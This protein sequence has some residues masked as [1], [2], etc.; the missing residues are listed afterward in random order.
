MPRVRWWRIWWL[1]LP[2]GGSVETPPLPEH[3]NLT[4]W[5]EVVW[6]ASFCWDQ[7]WT[8][9]QCCRNGRDLDVLPGI[10]QGLAKVRGHPDC[11]QPPE[12]G[13]VYHDNCCVLNANLDKVP[14]AG[15]SSPRRWCR[16]WA[17]RATVKVASSVGAPSLVALAKGFHVW[18]SD[19]RDE[20]AWQR[21]A[22]ARASSFTEAQLKRF[23]T[24]RLDL[25]DERTW[26]HGLF[27]D[28]IFLGSP[29]FMVGPT[30]EQQAAFCRSF[31]RLLA[32]H[33]APQ[34]LG[35]MFLNP[36]RLEPTGGNIRQTYADDCLKR[37]SFAVMVHQP[38]AEGRWH[39]KWLQEDTLEDFDAPLHLPLVFTL[40]RRNASIF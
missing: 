34:G 12:E 25:L 20:S 10:L 40:R 4:D 7:D 15:G 17:C 18:S 16:R 31:Q 36:V 23:R 5:R 9:F 30:S 26:P 24:P 29:F 19:L 39:S 8:F 3:V 35:M 27:F 11:W 37:S 1:W 21:W 13:P 32:L 6:D 2:R 14:R 22:G 38:V 33:L 28:V